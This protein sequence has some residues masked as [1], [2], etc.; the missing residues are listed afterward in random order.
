MYRRLAHALPLATVAAVLAAA[1]AHAPVHPTTPPAE[2]PARVATPAPP[3]QP[4][5]DDSAHLPAPAPPRRAP[6][7]E[8]A[9]EPYRVPQPW[10]AL[11]ECESGDWLDGGAAFVAGSARWAWGAT[12]D[13]LPPWG[14]VI[15]RGNGPEAQFHGGLQHH[16]DTWRWKAGEL[17]YLDTY[18]HAYDAPPEVQVEVATAVQA[19]QGW[20]AWPV[21]SRK[22]GLR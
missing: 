1:P 18:P 21:C 6:E 9:P 19:A 2:P 12:L 17:G 11:A 8:P 7:P 10:K 3:P 16:P 15:D 20:E 5:A 22:V 13:G 4:W 14:S